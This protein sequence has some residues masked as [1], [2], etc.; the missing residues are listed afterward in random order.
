MLADM[1]AEKTLVGPRDSGALLSC[2]WK[3]TTDV[4]YV[5]QDGCGFI[6]ADEDDEDDGVALFKGAEGGVSPTLTYTGNTV[7]AVDTAKTGVFSSFCYM[8]GTDNT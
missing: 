7:D 1:N 8:I 6:E 4:D 2:R 5:F 3:R